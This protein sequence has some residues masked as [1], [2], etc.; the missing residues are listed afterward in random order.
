[1]RVEYRLFMNYKAYLN[2][3]YVK[4]KQLQILLHLNNV[5]AHVVTK[6]LGFAEAWMQHNSHGTICM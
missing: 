2:T 3:N 5:S 4:L 6:F 1:M